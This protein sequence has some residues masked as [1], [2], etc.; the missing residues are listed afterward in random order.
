MKKAILTSRFFAKDH[1]NLSH[2]KTTIK[3]PATTE[4]KLP[5]DKFTQE[6]IDEVNELKQKTIMKSEFVDNFYYAFFIIHFFVS[7]FIDLSGLVGI[8]RMYTKDLIYNYI[9]TYN[10]F[11]LFERPTWF[12]VFIFIETVV[13][14]PMF[15][16]FFTI[17]NRFY[18]E[19]K[20][21]CFT[22]LVKRENLFR[23]KTWRPIIRVVL[24]IYSVLASSTTAYCCYVI[25]TQG[26]YPGTSTTL[27]D[28]DTYKLLALYSPM[29]Y[30][31]LGI[32]FL[33]N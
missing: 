16:W 17:F 6:E 19:K 15:M 25:Y 23:L 13:Q 32:L 22:V 10:D 11:L 9:K 30:I 18:D 21:H 20:K 1:R 3:M 24:R 2:P 8:E 33:M 12:R 14:I 31:P 7:L 4:K 5:A 29:I 26:H 28:I 27:T